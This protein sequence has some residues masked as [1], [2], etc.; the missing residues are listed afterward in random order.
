MSL[1]AEILMDKGFQKLY[2]L[3]NTLI[4]RNAKMKSAGLKL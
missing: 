4:K 1:Q 2:K 3:H